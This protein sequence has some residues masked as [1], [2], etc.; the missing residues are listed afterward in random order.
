[1]TDNEKPM[2]LAEIAASAT[3]SER[4][5]T[6]CVAGHLNSRYDELERAL[7]EASRDR[8]LE[9]SLGDVDPRRTIAEEM[10]SI[11]E[12]MAA[13]EHTFILRALPGKAWSDLL[14]EH[15]PRK[16]TR[17]LFNAQTLPLA[18]VA[19]SLVR[20]NGED[21]TTTV[22]ELTPLWDEAL[23]QGQRDELFG[24]AWEANTGAVSVPFSA[25][26]SVILARTDVK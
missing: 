26:A 18:C 1:M 20:L 25:S 14:L 12:Q 24:A 23:N 11:R 17:E 4:S 16:D 21:I 9:R 2:S 13:H 15:P 6:L 22:A 19:A 5:V 10:E 7:Q 8:G 3:R